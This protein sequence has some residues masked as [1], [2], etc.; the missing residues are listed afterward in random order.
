MTMIHHENIP[1]EM[2]VRSSQLIL[3]VQKSD[4]FVSHETVSILPE[5]SKFAGKNSPPYYEPPYSDPDADKNQTKKNYPPFNRMVY[6][7]KVVKELF[8][9][10]EKPVAGKKIQVVA[11]DD[12]QRLNL[13]K[14]YYLAGKRKSPV[15]LTYEPSFTMETIEKTKEFIIFANPYGSRYVF[16]CEDAHEKLDTKKAIKKLIQLHLN[17]N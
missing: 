17:G 11:A 9:S 2:L 1:L 6:H 7:F 15:F 8:N 5:G 3:V 12:G 14:M 10:T 16:S 13:H 4:P